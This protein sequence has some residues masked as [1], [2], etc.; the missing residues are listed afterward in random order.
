MML[1]E[2]TFDLLFVL[3]PLIIGIFVGGIVIPRMMLVAV[4]DDWGKSPEDIDKSYYTALEVSGMSLFPVWLFTLCVSVL[5]PLFFD[6]GRFA[7]AVYEFVPRALFL[8]SGAT[9]LYIIG[10][11]YDLHGSSSFV[12]M[13]S[14]LIA[15]SLL[16]ASGLCITDFHG[17]FGI[18][19]VPHWMGFA[20]TLCL[21]A[22]MIELVK[23]LDGMESLAGTTSV[24]F[25]FLLLAIALIKEH[26]IVA[27][28]T[29]GALGTLLPL[30]AMKTMNPKWKKTILGNSGCYLLGY[31]LAYA[32]ISL[33]AESGSVDNGETS[34][35][36]FSI[37]MMPMLDIFRVVV[38]RIRDGRSVIT[39]DR[40]QINFK[41]HR[42]GLS[43]C[44]IYP[45]YIFLIVLFAT[46]TWLMIKADVDFTLVVVIDVAMWIASELVMN[47]F[48]YARD[49]RTHRAAW[50]KVYG[51]DA[52]NANVPYAQIEAKH[53]T[54]GNMGLEPEFINGTE[55][56]FIP[57]G[58][59][60]VENWTKRFFDV[61]VSGFCLVVFS[62]LFLLSYILIKLDDGGPAIFSQERIGRFG[63]PFN[64]YKYRSM[65]LDAEAMGPQLSHAGGEDDPRLTKVGRFLRAHHLDELPQLW[66]VFC[67][68]MT[69]IGYRPERKFYIDQI[70]EHD[71]RYAFLY[72]IRPGVTS[73]ATLYNGYTDTMEKMLRRLELDL[74]YLAHRSMWF[75][76]KILFLTFISII[77][78]K[79]F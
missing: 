68:D 72:Q 20:F 69:L 3:V 25:F 31:I 2:L 78:G 41:L 27:M 48:I 13:V 42:T 43:A 51:R 29:A 24:T 22:C 18:H 16:L 37:L 28:V 63:R 14:V 6:D 32:V 56:D 21:S 54:F 36:I 66:N 53:K 65:R 15:S 77:F 64:I 45:V 1:E 33:S 75:D 55:L 74:Y 49:K 58:M 46:A 5:A 71:P 8:I 47:Y 38:S 23:L 73:Y 19:I 17:L 26:I 10:L 61:C 12:R 35:L 67:G 44:L 30:W 34:V 39:P 60:N 40:N 7:P 76:C 79:K 70:M 62:P 11:K 50:N 9:V 52:W 57:D 59:N 4:K